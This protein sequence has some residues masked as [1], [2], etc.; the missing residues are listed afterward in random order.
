MAKIDV[1]F[2]RGNNHTVEVS[3]NFGDFPVIKLQH[4]Y[5]EIRRAGFT[6]P[7]RE[8]GYKIS[9]VADIL[10]L[11]LNLYNDF[12]NLNAGSFNNLIDAFRPFLHSHMTHE[13]ILERLLEIKSP[14]GWLDA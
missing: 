14:K 3:T 4:E 11:M 1:R 12:G 7:N 10:I 8:L 2:I 13:A 5:D 6:K 9:E